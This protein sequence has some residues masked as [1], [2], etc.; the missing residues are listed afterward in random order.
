MAISD[1]LQKLVELKNQLVN[2]LVSKGVEATT[3]EKLNTLVPK[4]LE[5][6]QNT[7]TYTIEFLNGDTV[8]DGV[9]SVTNIKI[10]NGVTSIG[11]NAF[12]GCSDLISIIIP[13]SITTIGS[14]AF[15]DCK[16]LLNVYFTGT[17]T[18]WNSITIDSFNTPL[19]DARK[20]F[21]YTG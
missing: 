9:K 4:V 6:G 17:E 16:S 13:K 11:T 2:N 20:H 21:N 1:Y 8:F 14:K 10:P 15:G 19:I 3:E 12:G 18:E 5:I 7:G